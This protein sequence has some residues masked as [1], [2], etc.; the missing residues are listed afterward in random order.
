MSRVNLLPVEVRRARRDAALV[1]RIR[2]IGICGL[3]L[4]GGL[5][6]VRTYEVFSLGAQVE[7]V[8]AEQAAVQAEFD[9]LSDVAAARDAAV[10]AR[11]LTQQ[12]LSGEISWSQQ[13][14]QVAETVP[15]GFTLSSLAGQAA[16]DPGTGIVGS[17][18]FS[19]TSSQLLVTRSW[20]VRMAAQEGW[21]NAWVSS[22]SSD[23][24][25]FTVAGSVDLTTASV[26]DR[27]GA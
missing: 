6:G 25:P 26:T 14:L 5:Y 23:T 21:A 13:L 4:L 3:L 10:A 27:G 7:D 18:T 1:H 19:A 17:I 20:L 12:L 24:G 8:R 22:V 15:S 9:S 2:F 16:P 11:T